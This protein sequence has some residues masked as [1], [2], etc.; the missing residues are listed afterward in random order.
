MLQ[1]NYHFMRTFNVK[2]EDTFVLNKNE[3]IMSIRNFKGRFFTYISLVML[4]SR[5]VTKNETAVPEFGF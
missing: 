4:I 5:K 1:I 3:K 2:E